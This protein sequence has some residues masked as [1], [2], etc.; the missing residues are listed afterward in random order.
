MA[1]RWFVGTIGSNY[2]LRLKPT[3]YTRYIVQ[4]FKLPPNQAL[5]STTYT[6]QQ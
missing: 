1:S 4:Q 3:V 6:I 2:K 5:Q